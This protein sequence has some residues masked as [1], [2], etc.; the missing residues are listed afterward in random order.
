MILYRVLQSERPAR[1]DFLSHEARG[2]QPCGRLSGLAA[3]EW[4]GVSTFDTVLAARAAAEKHNLGRFIAL[5]DV[6]E[7]GSVAI[8][9]TLRLPSRHHFT[10]WA[11]AAMLQARIVRIFPVEGAG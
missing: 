4:A 5:L 11:E 2:L 10:V 1:W 6:P 9:Q 7:D 8:A 3:I